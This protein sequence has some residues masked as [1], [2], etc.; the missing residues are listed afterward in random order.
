MLGLLR[1]HSAL[2][3]L[4]QISDATPE[5]LVLDTRELRY[6][7]DGLTLDGTT[8]TFDS[9]NR[10]ARALE[11]APLFAQVQVADAKQSADGSRIDFRLQITL[12]QEESS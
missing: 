12:S 8:D 11:Q 2:D 6:E 10:L 9:V 1:S 5:D 4:R 3:I 7:K